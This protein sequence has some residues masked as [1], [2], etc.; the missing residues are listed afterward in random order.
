MRKLAI[1]EVLEEL[2]KVKAS[3]SD[4][5]TATADFG[6]EKGGQPKHV[7]YR[8]EDIDHLDSITTEIRNTALEIRKRCV[9]GFDGRED[10]H[11]YSKIGQTR[12]T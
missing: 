2:V 5:L 4:I 8:F 7:T 6:V 11:V 12:K 1:G 9:L 10:G 3:L